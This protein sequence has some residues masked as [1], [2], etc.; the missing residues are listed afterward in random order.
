VQNPLNAV[1]EMRR[2]N[3]SNNNQGI[4]AVKPSFFKRLSKME[5][6][7][8]ANSPQGRKL[9]GGIGGAYKKIRGNRQAAGKGV[10]LGGRGA[11]WIGA[12]KRRRNRSKGVK[13]PLPPT[14][15]NLL[16]ATVKN[17]ATNVSMSVGGRIPEQAPVVATDT[18][19]AD[20]NFY[21]PNYT[22]PI[23]DFIPICGGNAENFPR[24]AV[25]SSQYQYSV[26][27][28][29][30]VLWKNIN[31]T[32]F[33]GSVHF[34][35]LADP[36]S[37]DAVRASPTMVD[38][39]P[40]TYV[41]NLGMP[42]GFDIS[43]MQLN[44][45][46]KKYPVI[47]PVKNTGAQDQMQGYLVWYVADVATPSDG[48]GSKQV[49]Q[50]GSIAVKYAEQPSVPILHQDVTTYFVEGS[51]KWVD[52]D[53][54]IDSFHGNT[55][56]PGL[57][58]AFTML[59]YTGTGDFADAY[60]VVVNLKERRAIMFEVISLCTPAV[61]SGIEEPFIGVN[62]TGLEKTEVIPYASEDL[63]NNTKV[64]NIYLLRSTGLT[65]NFRINVPVHGLLRQLYSIDWRYHH[66]PHDMEDFETS[67][68]LPELL[69]CASSSAP[70]K[71]FK[72]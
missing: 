1:G 46:F 40:L 23:V 32:G 17:Q 12:P 41:M 8:F 16:A 44:T 63:E 49:L 34:G 15:S 51:Y 25:V 67:F 13:A 48:W 29:L 28:G 50:V 31:G 22:N 43:G 60:K 70:I 35:I 57:H 19:I 55:V 71:S 30:G 11:G 64:R 33:A 69:A 20:V 21:T 10:F 66:V 59:G 3:R 24:G 54:F 39:L 45:Q 38:Q 56:F 68:E 37:L 47:P 18:N 42:S 72:K 4:V 9:A 26:F 53:G 14:S 65:H 61:E 5:A 6:L 36:T 27:K 58:F 7:A 52:V 62:V 2:R